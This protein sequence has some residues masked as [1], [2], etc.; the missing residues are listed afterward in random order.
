MPV[1]V[2]GYDDLMRSLKNFAPALKVQLDRDIAKVMHQLQIKAR[3]YAPSAFPKTLHNW[4]DFGRA[5]SRGGSFPLYDDVTVTNGI[6]YNKGAAK[7]NQYGFSAF[8]YVANTSAAGSIYETAGRVN[9]EGR[10]STH[11]VMIDKRFT[12]RMIT[13]KTTKDSQSRN[14]EAAAYFMRELNKKGALYGEG[15]QR[16]RMIFRAWEQDRGKAQDTIILAI[17]KTADDFNRNYLVV[18]N[19]ALMAA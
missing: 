14:P 15:K 6:I 13:V 17:Q 9:P 12:R 8:H 2:E 18:G 1:V 7:K 10:K 3:G 19:Y 4:N 5:R 11:E 16:G